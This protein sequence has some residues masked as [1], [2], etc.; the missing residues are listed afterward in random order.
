MKN[1]MNISFSSLALLSV[2]VGAETFGAVL[3][4]AELSRAETCSAG[5]WPNPVNCHS[6][7]CMRYVTW[8]GCK[9]I[10]N[11]YI[12]G[13]PDPCLPIY[14]AT[15]W[16]LRWKN[17][18]CLLLR[19][20]M[21]KAKVSENFLSPDKNG[22]KFDGFWYLGVRGL[23]KFW[24]LLQKARPCEHSH[25]LSHFAWKTDWGVWPPGW[26]GKTKIKSQRSPIRMKSRR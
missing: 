10:K 25:C 19:P 14:C 7:L 15:F 11:N 21:L 12:F 2:A 22:P 23:T 24:F 18:C 17:K 13:I 20:L 16:G 3:S 9:G 4:S 1:K 5:S 26:L 8:T 6:K